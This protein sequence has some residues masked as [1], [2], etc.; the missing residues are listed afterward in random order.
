PAPPAPVGE[1]RR[2]ERRENGEEAEAV[3]PDRR[4]RLQDGEAAGKVSRPGVADEVPGKAG[5]DVSA[6]PF[7]G[8]PGNRERE[9]A[10]DPGRRD[11][12]GRGRRGA[13]EEP[14]SRRESGGRER[15]HP[16]EA[17]EVDGERDRDPVKAGEEEAEAEPP[18]D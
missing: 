14:E 3:D 18:S 15:H 13:G 2:Q 4:R 12:P 9:N 11:E 7:G 6:Q 5:Q 10:R 17:R 8:A 1:R 16:P